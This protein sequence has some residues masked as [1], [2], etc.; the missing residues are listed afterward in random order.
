MEGLSEGV[1]EN[2]P[3]GRACRVFFLGGLGLAWLPIDGDA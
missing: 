1:D 3:G 2:P